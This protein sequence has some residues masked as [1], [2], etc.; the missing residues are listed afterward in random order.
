MNDNGATKTAE[1]ETEVYYPLWQIPDGIPRYGHPDTGGDQ[2][3]SWAAWFWIDTNRALLSR[4]DDVSGEHAKNIGHSWHYEGRDIDEFHYYEMPG[5]YSGGSNYALLQLNASCMLN[6][7]PAIRAQARLRVSN[8]VAA[9]RSGLTALNALIDVTTLYTNRGS[10][11]AG[12]ERG[13]AWSL[14]TSGITTVG[15]IGV[16]LGLGAWS[17]EKC[18]PRSDHEDHIH[19]RLDDT[20]L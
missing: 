6:T 7:D 3:C 18:E 19:V 8:W 13:W 10:A 2:W 4:V 20:F 1:H 17:C 16:N 15:G 5:A 11:G 14:L 9:M 12:L